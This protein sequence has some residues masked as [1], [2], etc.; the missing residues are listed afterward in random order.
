[1]P[2]CS[3][4]LVKSGLLCLLAALLLGVLLAEAARRP[5]WRL[6][7]GL[8]LGYYHLFLLGGVTQFMFGVAIWL[9]PRRPGRRAEDDAPAA[10]T[11]Y[12]LL[13]GG[14]ALRVVFEPW[15]AADPAP[16]RAGLLVVAAGLQLAAMLLI[17]WTLWRRVRC[18]PQA[19]GGKGRAT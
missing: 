19:A 14:L 17:A 1:M 8:Q 11:V 18:V 2:R 4:W 6:P 5:E 13:N 7:P 10:W 3:R 12:A 15:H 16:L 9:L